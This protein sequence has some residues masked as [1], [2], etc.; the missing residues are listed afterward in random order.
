MPPNLKLI[1]QCEVFR[2]RCLFCGWFASKST[3]R[4]KK[5]PSSSENDLKQVSVGGAKNAQVTEICTTD[6]NNHS[7]IKGTHFC[8]IISV[9]ELLLQGTCLL[10]VRV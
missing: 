6:V 3:L 7:D 1:Q 8:L 5:E 4:A 2:E 10:C 9:N